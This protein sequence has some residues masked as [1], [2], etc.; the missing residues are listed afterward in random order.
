MPAPDPTPEAAPGTAPRPSVVVT[1]AVTPA[2]IAVISR[3]LD[4]FNAETSG[5]DDSAPL[6]VL[7]R[8]PV[9]GRVIGGLTGHTSRGMLFV[10]LF[11]LPPGLRGAG[12]GSE[13]LRQAEDEARARGCRTAVLYTLSFQAPDFYRKQG[14]TSMGEVPCDPPGTSRVFLSKELVGTREG[15]GERGAGEVEA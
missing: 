4:G 14:W 12:L 6:A 10:D 11:F 7:V 9:E 5:A 3:G 2:D 8:E 13:I 15:S 1:D